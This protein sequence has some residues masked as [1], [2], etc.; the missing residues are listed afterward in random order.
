LATRLTARLVVL[1]ATTCGSLNSVEVAFPTVHGHNT[2][3]QH[4]LVAAKQLG[5]SRAQ[6]QQGRFLKV[7]KLHDAGVPF[8]F[9][10]GTLPYEKHG[11]RSREADVGY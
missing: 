3:L 1:L 2:T 5:I 6:L 10:L 7:F 11:Q 8:L 9:P 4:I